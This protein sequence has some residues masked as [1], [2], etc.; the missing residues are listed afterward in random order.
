MLLQ[1]MFNSIHPLIHHYLL[2]YHFNKCTKLSLSSEP[3][4]EHTLKTVKTDFPTKV[5]VICSFWKRMQ[6]SLLMPFSSLSVH[7]VP[8][9]T[10]WKEYINS[11]P[12]CHVS[13]YI[14]QVI[15][16]TL[17]PVWK[18]AE[19]SVR[20]LCNGDYD[21]K[22]KVCILCMYSDWSQSSCS[23]FDHCIKHKAVTFCWLQSCMCCVEFTITSKHR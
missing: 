23:Y 14:F 17:N 10:W 5:V 6:G 8:L 4:A 18:P 15:K 20:N 22:L 12:K 1:F 2:F 11:Y 19:V 3:L 7:F 13:L 21:K 16:N 9:W